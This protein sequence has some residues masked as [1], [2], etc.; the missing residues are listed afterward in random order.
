MDELQE[1]L[2]K[3]ERENEHLL[4]AMEIVEQVE[5]IIAYVE[6][7]ELALAAAKRVRSASTVLVRALARHRDQ[8]QPWEGTST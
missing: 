6:Q 7:I 2:H 8:L 5:P 3:F 1:A 4:R